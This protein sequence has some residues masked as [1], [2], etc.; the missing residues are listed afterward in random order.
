MREDLPTISG[1]DFD[2]GRSVD[3]E[4]TAASTSA[5]ISP[6]TTDTRKRKNRSWI[7]ANSW[8]RVLTVDGTKKLQCI[9][10][11]QK[12]SYQNNTTSSAI[13][14]LESH[15]ISESSIR[16]V[17]SGNQPTIAAAFASNRNNRTAQ[18]P[19]S[20][21]KLIC[22]YLLEGGLPYQSVENSSFQELLL[23]A[24]SAPNASHILLPT[25]ETVHSWMTSAYT[26]G[27]DK[28]I[29]ELKLQPSICYTT[30][31]GT[32]DWMDP[33]LSITA[34]W[35]DKEWNKREFVIGFESITELHTGREYIQS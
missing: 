21:Q 18:S 20:F 25:A 13:R 33:Y 16:N 4:P 22:D 12:F 30:G 26:D 27:M 9:K 23:Y 10:C 2:T 24:Q 5:P 32:G 7:I 31:L 15:G 3:T 8:V 35:I 14:H 1:D 29:E 11:N 6:S 17:S 34:H 19:A 28:I